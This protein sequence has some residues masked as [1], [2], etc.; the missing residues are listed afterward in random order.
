MSEVLGLLFAII[1]GLT[2]LP[3]LS[4]YSQK[5]IDT[6]RAV[7]TA[8]QQK[9]LIEA[10]TAYIQQYSSTLQGV[11]TPTSPAIITVP[12]LQDPSVKLL[13]AS[14][15]STNPFGQTWQT[16]VL[17]PSPGNLQA[18]VMSY[19][20]SALGDMDASKIAGLVGAQG[21]FFPK[22]DTGIYPA[23]FAYGSYGGWK[24]STAGYTSVAGGRLAALLS[25]NNG[26]LTSNYLYR[27]S[28]PG[29]PQLN[30]MGTALDMGNNNLNNA[31][32]VNATTVATTAAVTAGTR[33]TAGEY[34]QI[35]GTVVEG[36]ACA[37]NDLVAR[38]SSGLILSCQSGMWLNQTVTTKGWSSSGGFIT[39]PNAAISYPAGSI[40]TG[41]E[42]LDSSN[43]WVSASYSIPINPIKSGLMSGSVSARGC[44][45]A[46]GTSGYVLHMII[47]FSLIDNDS[48]NVVASDSV[49]S[50]PLFDT[51]AAIS[52][53]VVK[54]ITKNT[55]GYT[56]VVSNQWAAQYN[57]TLTPYYTTSWTKNLQ[58]AITYDYVPQGFNWN[59]DLYY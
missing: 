11:A 3:K 52:L 12:M 9:Q 10:S 51:C 43:G 39:R 37:S 45:R 20:G 17:Q 16:A 55:K 26:Q 18:L 13:N 38:D 35:K 7:T 4:S 36:T 54:G 33:V 15:A 27:N 23:G 8:E 57:G 42:S 19:G 49:Q 29:Q 31:A 5:S 22:N 53:P 21:G 25:F 40:Y 59:L 32:T 44:Y 2:F 14:F 1:V 56:L 46:D 48:N 30:R 58:G 28:V 24:T 34:V 41:T 47:S 50:A 6:T